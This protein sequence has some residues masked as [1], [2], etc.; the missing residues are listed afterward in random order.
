MSETLE[1]QQHP[2]A[3]V[4][5]LLHREF[6]AE[7]TVAEGRTVDVRIVPYGEKITHNDGHGGVPRGQPYTEEWASGAFNHQLNAAFR[8]IANVEHEQ[9][10][11][12]MIGHGLALRDEPDGLHGSFA[13]H[14]T[15]RG[16]TALELIRG[17][18]LSGVS[19]EARPR[20]AVKLA[21]GAIRRTKADLV[22]VAFTRFGA[23]KN[24][25][26][27]AV[28][29]E[30]EIV[31]EDLLPVDMDPELVERLRARGVVLPD[32]YKAHPDDT[33]TPAD[34]GTSE[35]GTRQTETKPTSEENN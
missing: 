33:D 21:A 34:A 18:V 4:T 19:L 30:A 26:V 20:A 32:R 23:Y 12:G 35:D 22:N 25:L 15:D 10:V 1:E 3:P 31:D 29:E 5:G 14:Q 24:A 2:E 9:G 13:I 7:L 27:L 8:V 16:E 6:A 17:G 28:R 11:A